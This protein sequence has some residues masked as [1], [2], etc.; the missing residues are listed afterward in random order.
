MELSRRDALLAVLGSGL[1]TGAGSIVATSVETDTA[2]RN[3]TPTSERTLSADE[4]TSL[5]A[6]AEV[7]Y[8][9]EVEVTEG[10]LETYV[11]AQPDERR[12]G[13]RRA[14]STLEDRAARWAGREFAALPAAKRDVLLREM[15]VDR[16]HGFYRG[17]RSLSRRFSGESGSGFGPR[18]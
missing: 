17:R 16:V 13:F 18:R 8:P 2:G 4:L 9:S 12:A 7:L 15:G 10:F 11:G 1:T 3:P 6:L 5:M 14:L